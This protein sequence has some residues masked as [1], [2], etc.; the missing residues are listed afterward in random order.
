MYIPFL[1]D[2]YAQNELQI[3]S[4]LSDVFRTFNDLCQKIVHYV[5][6]NQ[7]FN[8][9]YVPGSVKSAVQTGV[10]N[11]FLDFLLSFQV[12]AVTF[13]TPYFHISIHVYMHIYTISPLML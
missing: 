4:I 6:I 10:V 9:N 8:I 7:L 3:W 1:V 12:S 5:K 13:T 11:N 2:F